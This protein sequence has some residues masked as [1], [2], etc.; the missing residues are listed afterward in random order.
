MDVFDEDD[1]IAGDALVEL[2]GKIDELEALDDPI[3]WRR[4]R[5]F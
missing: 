2:I 1:G 3:V 4:R 5:A